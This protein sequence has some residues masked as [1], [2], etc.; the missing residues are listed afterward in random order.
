MEEIENVESHFKT[1]YMMALNIFAKSLDE[2]VSVALN[3]VKYALL[4]YFSH[5]N[6]FKFCKRLFVDPIPVLETSH[7]TFIAHVV[8]VEVYL[9]SS[10]DFGP[11]YFCLLHYALQLRLLRLLYFT[12]F[13]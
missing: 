1:L 11:P 4:K 7:I 2:L 10:N 6:K 9:D 3:L 12:L 5:G 8:H 13:F